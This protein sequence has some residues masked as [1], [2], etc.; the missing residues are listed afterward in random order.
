MFYLPIPEEYIFRKGDKVVAKGE[1]YVGEGV[2]KKVSYPKVYWPG[3]FRSGA[4]VKV[5]LLAPTY[6]YRGVNKGL[7]PTL[8]T[9]D[10]FDLIHGYLQRYS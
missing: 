6:I 4:E 2:V 5:L 1:Y 10:Y 9:Y 7:G 8:V 3:P